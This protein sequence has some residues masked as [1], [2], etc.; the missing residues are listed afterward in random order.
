LSSTLI[1]VMMD[2]GGKFHVTFTYPW[3]GS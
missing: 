2:I 3:P 1:K